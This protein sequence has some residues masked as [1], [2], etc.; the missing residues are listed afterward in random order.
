MAIFSRRVLQRMLLE[1]ARLDDSSA[2]KHA[3]KLNRCTEDTISTEW[4]VAVLNGLSKLGSVRHEPDSDAPAVLDIHFESADGRLKFVGDVVTVTDFGLEAQNP[5]QEFEREVARRAR[6]ANLKNLAGFTFEYGSWTDGDFRD[7]KV[8]IAVPNHSKYPEFFDDEFNKWLRQV[9]DDRSQRHVYSKQAPSINL[10]IVFNPGSP[11]VSR[12]S[13]D[14]RV[15]QSLTRNPLFHALDRKA[16]QFKRARVPNPTVIFACDGASQ[17]MKER[18]NVNVFSAS[19]IVARFFKDHSVSAVVFVRVERK[20]LSH[21][22][23]FGRPFLQ[24]DV[25]ENSPLPG[26]FARGL[27]SLSSQLAVAIPQPDDD[28][29]NAINHLRWK[30]RRL[31]LSNSGGFEMNR[32]SVKMSARAVQELLAGRMTPET[33][34]KEH[35]FVP[36]EGRTWSFNPFELALKNGRLIEDVTIEKAENEDDDWITFFFSSRDA[37]IDSFRIK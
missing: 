10:T 37:A 32:D 25:I 27:R 36:A 24:I 6:K 17:S 7:R 29:L 34:Q 22:F 30:N 28:V 33:F 31:G 2:Q 20:M 23:A 1:N 5:I 12:H 18:S 16:D 26:E 13:A 21:S 8:Y 35:A 4:E 19:D 9:C 3:R 14:F 11:H 15:P